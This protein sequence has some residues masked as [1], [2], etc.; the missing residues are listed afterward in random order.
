MEFKEIAIKLCDGFSDMPC[1]CEACPLFD[2]D[3]ELD[4]IEGE[5]LCELHK[6]LKKDAYYL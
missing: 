2:E 1:G 6:A 5:P 3:I 4:E